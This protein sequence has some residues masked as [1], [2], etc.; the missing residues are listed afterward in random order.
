MNIGNMLRKRDYPIIQRNLN[1]SIWCLHF[2]T[3]TDSRAY[4]QYSDFLD[5]LQLLKQGFAA[6]GLTSSLQ[7]FYDR[8]HDLVD[9][10][11]ISISQMTMDLLLF[12]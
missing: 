9:R 12:T 7:S 3:H 5:R 2:T 8:H 6:P 1:S 10:Y 11:E 4:V